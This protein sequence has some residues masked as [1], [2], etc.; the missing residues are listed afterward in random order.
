MYKVLPFIVVILISLH[1]SCVGFAAT[2]EPAFLSH[3]KVKPRV[4]SARTPLR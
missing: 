3:S 2:S 1:V 4:T